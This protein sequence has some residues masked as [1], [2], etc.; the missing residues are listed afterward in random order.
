MMGLEISILWRKI[1]T[2]APLTPRQVY[3]DQLKFMKT[4]EAE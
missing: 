3:E 4:K 2:F 1:Y